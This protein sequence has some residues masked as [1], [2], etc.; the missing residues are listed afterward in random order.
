[1]TRSSGARSRAVASCSAPERRRHRSFASWRLE[2]LRGAAA[3]EEEDEV[4]TSTRD[5]LVSVADGAS[6]LDLGRLRTAR[7]RA[8]R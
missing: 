1:M 2:A 3:L 8:W 6:T 7:G 5:F 4:A